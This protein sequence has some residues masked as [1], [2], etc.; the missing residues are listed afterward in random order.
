MFIYQGHDRESGEKFRKEFEEEND[1][2]EFARENCS[3]YP[4]WTVT[5][6]ED[7]SIVDSDKIAE[8][9]ED[10]IMDDMFPEGMDE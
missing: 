3:S 9:E 4:K 5:D 2:K 6:S 10:G 8:D 1:A 7:D